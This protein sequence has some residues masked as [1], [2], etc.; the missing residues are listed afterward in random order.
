MIAGLL[1]SVLGPSVDELSRRAA[2]Q[3]ST[4]LAP[5]ASQATRQASVEVGKQIDRALVLS[6]GLVVVSAAAVALGVYLARRRS[7]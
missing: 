4:Q 7:A 6:F 5:L 3:A 1:D 2:Q